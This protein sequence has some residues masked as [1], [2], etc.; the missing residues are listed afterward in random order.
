MALDSAG[1]DI[2]IHDAAAHADIV[3]LRLLADARDGHWLEL[4][5]SGREQ[6]VRRADLER[7]RRTQ[8]R[9]ERHVAED[10][11]IGAAEH[12]SAA[13]EHQRDAEDVVRPVVPP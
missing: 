11:E 8:A 10:R 5:S 6:R 1:R 12:A 7:G 13:L 4:E 9:A 2:L 3:V